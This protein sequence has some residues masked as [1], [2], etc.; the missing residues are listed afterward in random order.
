[1]LGPVRLECVEAPETLNLYALDSECSGGLELAKVS[2]FPK[3]SQLI[4]DSGP[5]TQAVV[6]LGAALFLT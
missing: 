5:H 6:V 2:A 1:M 4:A 3:Q